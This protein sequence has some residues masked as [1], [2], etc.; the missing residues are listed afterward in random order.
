MSDQNHRGLTYCTQA[1]EACGLIQRAAQELQAGRGVTERNLAAIE[2]SARELVKLAKKLRRVPWRSR[3][4]QQSKLS[5]D[6][7][8]PASNQTQGR[9][10]P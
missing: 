1:R 7:R 2:S 4:S 5:L 3:E 6:P 9:R 8:T 10:G